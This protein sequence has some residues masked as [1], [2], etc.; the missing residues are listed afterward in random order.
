M[1]VPGLA[2][3]T[4]PKEFTVA[5]AGTLLAHVPPVLASVS[6]VVEPEHT[7]S[8]PVIVAIPGFTVT[9]AVLLQPLDIVYV[10]TVVPA[11]TPVTRP[12]VAPI[13]AVAGEP[14]THEP[15][16]EPPSTRLVNEPTHVLSVPVIGDMGLT[17]TITFVAQPFA[18]T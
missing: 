2:P 13:V 12:E 4:R 3:V 10:I 6:A 15:P 18:S 14:L 9:T 7:V 1:L 8:V 17:V 5:V 11:A 16:G